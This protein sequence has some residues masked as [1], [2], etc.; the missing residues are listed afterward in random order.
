MGERDELVD[1]T[2]RG[3]RDYTSRMDEDTAVINFSGINMSNPV[4][5]IA[6]RDE[7]SGNELIEEFPI[8]DYSR[9]PI[10]YLSEITRDYRGL[11][12]E[13]DTKT[14]YNSISSIESICRLY[15][16][17]LSSGSTSESLKETLNNIGSFL[18]SYLF[19]GSEDELSD[20]TELIIVPDGILAFIPFETLIMPDG[21]YLIEKYNI[22]YVQSLAVL[23][24]IEERTYSPGRKEMAAFGGAVYSQDHNSTVEKSAVLFEEIESDTL[25][26]LNTEDLS[27]SSYDELGLTKWIDL[28]GTLTEVIIIGNIIEGSEV[29]TGDVVNEKQIKRLS[30]EGLLSDY[31]ILHFATHGLVVPGLPELSALVLSLT[32]N[33]SSTED[34]FL[35]MKEIA[36]LDIEADFVNLSACETGLGKIYGGEGVVGLTQAFLIAGANSL[37]VSLWQVADES[38]MKF[39]TN[40]YRYAEE[41][42]S[43]FDS[44]VSAVK[45]LFI[46]DENY[47]HPYFWAPFVYYGN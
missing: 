42:K 43:S 17:I 30:N 32:G 25:F 7:I 4:R 23:Q 13:A 19:A 1:F 9:I 10:E 28:P 46:A 37:S 12:I 39:M 21:K 47:S 40:L 45:R 3:I 16:R 24:L 41:N 15:H 31:K 26:A 36:D 29:F 18:Y 38:T 2:F 33:E 14:L 11:S 22:R 20:I 5:V 35:T 44:A 34:G 8:I 6:N 27:R